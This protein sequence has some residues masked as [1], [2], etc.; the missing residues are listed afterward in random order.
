MF[1]T[2]LCDY[3]MDCWNHRNEMLHGKTLKDSRTITIE[4][5]RKQVRALYS[6]RESVRRQRNKKIFDMPLKKRLT[7]GIQSTKLWIDMAEEVLRLDRETA[8]KNTLDMWLMD[9]Q[10]DPRHP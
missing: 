2:T 6:K 3:S 8:T 5:L 4:K 10:G 1:A 9:R 7:M